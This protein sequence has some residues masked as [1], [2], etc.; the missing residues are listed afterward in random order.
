MSL[1]EQFHSDINKNYMF[2]MVKTIINKE[3]NKDVSGD[4]NY[5]SFITTLETVF[6]N[7]NSDD[8]SELNKILLDSEV[9]KYRDKYRPELENQVVVTNNLNKATSFEELI[10][11]REQQ[12]QLPV[13]NEELEVKQ[14]T[15]VFGTSIEKLVENKDNEVS[16]EVI[17]VVEVVE[18]VIEERLKSI[19]INSSQRK[20]INSSRYNYIIDLLDNNIESKDIRYVSKM[21][22]PI[23][24]NY[25][26]SIPVLILKIP[27]LNVL[28]HM[29]Q[30]DTITTP[31]GVF[32]IYIPIHKH[33]IHMN[34]ISKIT[35]Q[36]KDI[37]DT[38]FNSLD[39]LKVNIVQINNGKI[40][41]TC[42]NINSLNYKV[43]DNIKII[44]NHTYDLYKL[45]RTPLQINNIIDNIIYCWL[46]DKFKNYKYDNS[47]MKV[48]NLSN[49][50]IIFFNQQI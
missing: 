5:K 42:S 44:N 6:K 21:I 33:E 19:S 26:F 2:N 25:I 37:S 3:F 36:I 14:K 45:S 50:N 17:E 49:Q 29:Q 24:D 13:I 31:K 10:K 46:P 41:L 27:E 16:E 43:G 34:D 40:G 8:I 35:I 38:E 9:G 32:G 11:Q 39:I 1:F 20:S 18:E 30:E 15:N 7:N 12:N 47:D 22:I 23:E 48:L 4:E 28:I